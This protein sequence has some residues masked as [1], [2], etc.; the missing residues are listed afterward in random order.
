MSS[1]IARRCFIYRN[2]WNEDESHRPYRNMLHDGND[3]RCGLATEIESM[4]ADAGAVDGDEVEIIIRC[5]GNRP[6][7]GRIW[8]LLKAHTYGPVDAAAVEQ[9]IK[10]MP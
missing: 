8:K 9:K 4:F 3:K 1:D 10:E 2:Y 6:F 7:G 5:T